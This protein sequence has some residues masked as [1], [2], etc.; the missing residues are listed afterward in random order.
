ME[1]CLIIFFHPVLAATFYFRGRLYFR[2]QRTWFVLLEDVRRCHALSGT[3]VKLSFVKVG[4]LS[5]FFLRKRINAA[6]WMNFHSSRVCETF[7]RVRDLMSSIWMAEEN[8]ALFAI[9]TRIYSLIYSH[10]TIYF[11]FFY[12]AFRCLI[13][14]S[15]NI[16]PC[17]SLH[18]VE[19]GRFKNI[20]IKCRCDTRRNMAMVMESYGD[21]R[22]SA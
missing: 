15:D 16:Q 1:F 13:I 8:L 3:N 5:N 18:P 17:I 11:S 7:I 22:S 20:Q 12:A 21:D 2:F 4:F 9:L 10:S 19:A 14:I 6:D